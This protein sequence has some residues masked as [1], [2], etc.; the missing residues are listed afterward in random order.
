M[1]KK[2]RLEDVAVLEAINGMDRLKKHGDSRDFLFFSLLVFT[3][4]QIREILGLGWQDLDPGRLEIHI[5]NVVTFPAGQ[6]EPVV[7]QPADGSYRTIDLQSE[8]CKRIEPYRKKK[9]FIL[10]GDDADR[11]APMTRYEF[12]R[13]WM[14]ISRSLNL[15]G[16]GPTAFRK[17]YRKLLNIPAIHVN[18]DEMMEIIREL[19]FLEKY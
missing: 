6:N 3:E 7:R 12:D 11:N 18:P 15:K 19:V 1:E 17:A 14:R 5:Q 10:Y 8:L 9:G 13:M 16:A 4:L 2:S